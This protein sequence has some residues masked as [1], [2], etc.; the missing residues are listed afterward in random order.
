MNRPL[1]SPQIGLI[2]CG[3]W[4]KHIL[5]DLIGLRCQVSVVAR[6]TASRMR[7]QQGGATSILGEISRLRDVDGI[8]VCTPLSTHFD[9]I[10][11][12]LDRF[13]RTPVF[14]EKCLTN[15]L[16]DAANLASR[17]PERLFVMDKW[18]YHPGI[19]K[20]A[21][22]ARSNEFGKVI[23]IRTVKLGWGD[24]HP[25]TDPIWTHLPHDLSIVLEILGFIPE[26]VS[27]VA[28][29]PGAKVCGLTGIL[30][31]DPWSI[32]ELSVRS[33]VD[34]RE[35]RLHL[36]GGVAILPNSYSDCIEV[37]RTDA[38][39]FAKE[40]QVEKR[41]ISQ[42]MSLRAELE[43][44]IDYLAAKGAPPKSSVAEGKQIVETIVALRAMAGMPLD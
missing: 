21:A 22:I 17:A 8:V 29:L 10:S 36:E 13:P 26:P 28:D 30:G 37:I 35:V 40:P 20:L 39:S 23:G 6:S 16:P 2:G 25:D 1:S 32:C 14:S 5:R 12:V 43:A 15:N 3:N 24:P 41:A 44:F 38:P 27:A 31:R 11:E 7:A 19:K 9:V 33:A 18:R 4:G 34:L 42:E